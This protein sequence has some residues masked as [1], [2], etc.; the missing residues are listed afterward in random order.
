MT[1]CRVYFCS[2]VFPA[3]W[4]LSV[5]ALSELRVKKH[6]WRLTRYE[7]IY[8]QGFYSQCAKHKL[9]FLGAEIKENHIRY[10]YG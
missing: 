6:I 8:S 2:C 4:G 1:I 10:K 3:K 9:D 7:G 5:A